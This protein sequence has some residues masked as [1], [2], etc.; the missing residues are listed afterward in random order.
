LSL[1]INIYRGNFLFSPESEKIFKKNALFP[2]NPPQK[3]GA[4]PLI[5]LTGISPKRTP[6]FRIP[7]FPVKVQ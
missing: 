3:R 5:S 7:L 1:T 6:G 2:E 4:R